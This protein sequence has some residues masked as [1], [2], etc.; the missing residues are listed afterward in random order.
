[1]HEAPPQRK[2]VEPPIAPIPVLAA[3]VANIL[4]AFGP[5]LVRLSDVGPVAAGFWR[6]T[7]AAPLILG[8]ALASG[9]RGR[10]LS[11]KLWWLVL[12]GGVG[13]A[14]DLGSWHLGIL[15]TTLANATLFG[16]SA[17]LVFPIWG[18]LIARTWPTRRQGFALLLAA[19]GAAL[20][21][22]RSYSLD[23]RHLTGDLL[24]VVAGLFYTLYFICMSGARRTM[25]PLPALALSTTAS[26]VPLAIFS[27]A[28]G[29]RIWPEHWGAL[30]ALALASQV[31]GQGLMIY[32]LGTLPPLVVGLALLFQPV[33]SGTI[34]WIAYGERL[35]PLDFVGAALV[36]VA[37]VL[38]S[39]T[40]APEAEV[41]TA[42]FEED[43]EEA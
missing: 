34:G 40:R 41:A 32:A 13:F 31:F 18:F 37:L 23:P 35:G 22:G 29:E 20:L 30:V 14:L 39:R 24:C 11:P 28:L 1:M 6:I 5:W 43:R 25:A 26:I 36:A 27:L 21:L 7:L 16:N 33:V 42:A 12:A 4:L 10:G 9:W 8:A 3:A 2:A 17:T 15:R 38:V 19:A